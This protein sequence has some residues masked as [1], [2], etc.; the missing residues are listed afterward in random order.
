VELPEYTLP[1]DPNFHP[2]GISTWDPP[3]ST[4]SEAVPCPQKRY[5]AKNRG[6]VSTH[7][8]KREWNFHAT[9]FPLFPPKTATTVIHG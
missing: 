4:T 7:G 3:Y 9:D 5:E 6:I 1:L 8:W 2:R